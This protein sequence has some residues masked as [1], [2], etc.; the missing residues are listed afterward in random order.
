M[1]WFLW[2]L[3]LYYWYDVGSG[4]CSFLYMNHRNMLLIAELLIIMLVHFVLGQE[5]PE[6]Y[7]LEIVFFLSMLVLIHNQQLLEWLT[8]K[9]W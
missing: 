1:L 8:Y 4:L 5:W 9:V 2:I 3:I 6:F 7:I